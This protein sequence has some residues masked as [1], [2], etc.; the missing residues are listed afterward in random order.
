M[1][2]NHGGGCCCKHA[3]VEFITYFI[4]YYIK[5]TSQIHHFVKEFHAQNDYL[6]VPWVGVSLK[7]KWGIKR[8]TTTKRIHYDAYVNI[9]FCKK[10]LKKVKNTRFT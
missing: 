6:Q 8:L 2:P 10:N 9:S 3:V 1:Q 4:S 5:Y 7:E